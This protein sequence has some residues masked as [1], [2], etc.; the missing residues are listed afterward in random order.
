VHFL[1]ELLPNFF[2]V[3]GHIFRGGDA[4]PYRVSFD[5]EDGEHQLVY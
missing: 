3:H 4:L 2:P 1:A 5:Y